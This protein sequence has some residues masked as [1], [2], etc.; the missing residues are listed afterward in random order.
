MTPYWLK[1]L[2]VAEAEPGAAVGQDIGV[3]RGGGVQRRAHALA[4]LAVPLAAA[5][6]RIDA[7][8]LPE[9]QLGRMRA[10]PVATADERRAGFG[11]TAQRIVGVA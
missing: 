11:N 1:I 8:E 3:L 7:G 10:G 9:A 4:D 5:R 2:S 6:R